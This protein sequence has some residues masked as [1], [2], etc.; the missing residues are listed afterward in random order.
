MRFQ[1]QPT[2]TRHI[3]TPIDSFWR[4]MYSSRS[5]HKPQQNAPASG[6][7]TLKP[8]TAGKLH[9]PASHRPRHCP[10]ADEVWPPCLCNICCNFRSSDWGHKITST[11]SG[12][13][14]QNVNLTCSPA[15]SCSS[16][17]LG[18][19]MHCALPLRNTHHVCHQTCLDTK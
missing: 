19:D 18:S 4:N 10:S 15:S 3:P 2:L 9:V 8:Y 6:N 11:G 1:V 5:G 7:A 14:A 16:K 13:P 12:I 17:N